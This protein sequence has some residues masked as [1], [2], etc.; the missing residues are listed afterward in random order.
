GNLSWQNGAGDVRP[1]G[2][3][4][5]PPFN[6][7]PPAANRGVITL[8]NC[9]GGSVNLAGT[10]FQHNGD[11]ATTPVTVGVGACGGSPILPACV[12][13]PACVCNV[14]GQN[15]CIQ[16]SKFCTDATAPGAPIHFLGSVAN[17]GTETLNNVSVVDDSA[18]ASPLDDVT[19]LSLASL[20]PGASAPYS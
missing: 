20:A 3:D 9:T 10:T 8:D 5:I 19:V 7:D 17:C 2:D 11:T 14:A 18:T 4:T 15:A 16:V 6:D 12:T 13:L 1:T